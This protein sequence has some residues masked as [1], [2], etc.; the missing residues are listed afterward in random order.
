MKKTVLFLLLLAI[1]Q[2]GFSQRIVDKLD[3]GLVAQKVSKGVFLSWRILGEEYY[4]VTYNVYRNG[5]KITNTPLEVSNYTDV[6][7]TVSN[8]YSVSAVV[9]GVEQEQCVAVKP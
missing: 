3:R 9:R 7:G 1:A 6:S 8:S 4:D 5:V 2:W